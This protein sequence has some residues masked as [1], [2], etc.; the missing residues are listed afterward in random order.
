MSPVQP[1]GAVNGV[2]PEA[3]G[4]GKNSWR[5]IKALVAKNRVAFDSVPKPREAYEKGH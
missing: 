4:D 5:H 2:N 3:D 1:P